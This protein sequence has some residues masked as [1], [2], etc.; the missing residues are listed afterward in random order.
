M[1]DIHIFY[2]EKCH[3][4]NIIDKATQ[5]QTIQ[6]LN[7]TQF[8]FWSLSYSLMFAK[9]CWSNN[10]KSLC[11]HFLQQQ[12]I[13]ITTPILGLLEK[14]VEEYINDFMQS[15]NQQNHQGRC[16]SFS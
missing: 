16:F 1:N 9:W 10:L 12:H 8:G 13:L 7:C 14:C 5:D 6:L 2:E 11:G 4:I 15:L 3:N